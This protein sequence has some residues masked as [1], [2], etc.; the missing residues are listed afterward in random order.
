MPGE[1]NKFSSD[2]LDSSMGKLILKIVSTQVDCP[3]IL[4]VKALFT[5]NG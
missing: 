1:E 5:P 4:T 3:Q 2:F